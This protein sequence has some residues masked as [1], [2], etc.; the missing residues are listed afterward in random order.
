MCYSH[1]II[2]SLLYIYIIY[3]I[4]ILI[5]TLGS[6][7]QFA[8]VLGLLAS[9]LISIPLA[10]ATRWRYLFATTALLC[11]LQVN[12]NISRAIIIEIFTYYY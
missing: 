12:N 6:V 5:G 9:G 3:Y 1:L 8:M 4:P 7:T 11:L 10:R 2:Y